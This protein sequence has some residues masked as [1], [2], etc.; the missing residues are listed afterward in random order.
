MDKILRPV[1][2]DCQLTA[3]NVE[4]EWK[5]WLKTFENY[6][7]SQTINGTAEEQQAIKLGAL[8]NSLSASVYEYI[9]EAAT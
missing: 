8:T 6:V 4:K 9:S 1:R 2:F 5:H 7:A 3:P